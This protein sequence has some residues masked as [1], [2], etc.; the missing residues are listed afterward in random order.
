MSKKSPRNPPQLEDFVAVPYRKPG[1]EQNAQHGQAAIPSSTTT[2]KGKKSQAKSTH[3]PSTSN[4]NPV[5]TDANPFTGIFPAKTQTADIIPPVVDESV[6][7]SPSATSSSKASSKTKFV[8]LF[9]AHGDELE[10]KLQG[11]HPC[12]CMCTRH[13]LINNC[14]SCG[15]IVCVQEGS[16]PCFTCGSLVCTLEE[17]A[18][19]RRGGLDAEKTRRKIYGAEEL[20][21]DFKEILKV[22][23]KDASLSK[24]EAHKALL[25][26]F[27]RTAAQRTKIIDDQADYYNENTFMT[28]EQ[29][30]A[31]RE[32]E[33]ELRAVRFASKLE[34]N[35]Q[36][37]LDIA[38]RKFRSQADETSDMYDDPDIASRLDVN[39]NSE[40]V[41]NRLE[42][43]L[44]HR[45]LPADT[46]TFE[47]EL[48]AI[49]NLPRPV[50]ALTKSNAFRLQDRELQE[51]SDKG[52]ALSI[53]QPWG[54]FAVLGLKPHE[55]RTFYTAHRGK[56]WI[57]SGSK[58]L[59]A[60][61]VVQEENLI[62][63]L[64]DDQLIVFPEQYLTGYLLGCV[65]LVDCITQEEYQRRFPGGL[66]QQ[67]PYIFL[68]DNPV[69]LERKFPV[70]GQARIFSLDHRLHE[71][72]KRQ[73]TKK[74][75]KV[76]HPA[77]RSL[78]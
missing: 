77:E 63:A 57:A 70:S 78:D 52:L 41:L 61:E 2:K 33:K 43:Q 62:K 14:I 13:D 25:L 4:R 20:T 66:L 10:I 69:E 36:F 76:W 11:R 46:K 23:G 60:G 64:M 65:D 21:L 72:A 22:G 3:Q 53:M 58:M 71:L 16:G 24:A 55:G 19:L 18:N 45:N 32:K 12:Q 26:E 50:S 29:R 15:R 8:P 31:I 73:P 17:A 54:S 37:D 34:K 6:E 5:G 44:A 38:G 39:V 28:P 67:Y 68:F 49:P 56:L 59:P 48:A 74:P 9:S 1:L 42:E 27:D 47:E 40:D 30:K 7:E 51:M 75:G 35:R